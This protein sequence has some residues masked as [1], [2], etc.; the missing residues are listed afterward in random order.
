MVSW[1]DSKTDECRASQYDWEYNLRIKTS[2]IMMETEF[3]V[4]LWSEFCSRQNSRQIF[5]QEYLEFLISKSSDSKAQI[6]LCVQNYN[7]DE[8]FEV[9]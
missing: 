1:S 8:G 3:L 4:Q 5:K 9:R 6:Y 7:F 2:K